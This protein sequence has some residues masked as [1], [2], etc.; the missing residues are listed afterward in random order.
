MNRVSEG[1]EWM[2][3][4]VYNEIRE[5]AW[6]YY[7][8]PPE[9]QFRSDDAQE[10]F[11]HLMAFSEV[12]AWVAEQERH[13]RHVASLDICGQPGLGLAAGVSRALGWALFDGRPENV[14][15]RDSRERMIT[16]SIFDAKARFG[17]LK[18][19]D[20][21]KAQ[22][23][24]LGLVFFRPLAGM[25]KLGRRKYAHLYLYEYLLRPLYQRMEEGGMIFIASQELVGMPL[26]R[27]LLK[28]TEGV[29]V[30][31]NEAGW[32]YLI[33]K[34]SD[35]PELTSLTDMGDMSYLGDEFKKL[36]RVR[37]MNLIAFHADDIL[38]RIRGMF[39]R[40]STRMNQE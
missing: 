28:Q 10:G 13:G 19:L 34:R 30:V 4:D 7:D 32:G 8:S 35:I 39:K 27:E 23:I 2:E 15:G 11:G 5:P 40:R 1:N 17:V 26:L 12:Q 38:H 37:L 20:E 16:S 3:E 9:E 33:T 21:L 14:K 18:E 22:G 24:G 25:K 36:S 29:Q 6:N 31:Q